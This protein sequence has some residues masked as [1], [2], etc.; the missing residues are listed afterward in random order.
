MH[1]IYFGPPDH[2]IIVVWAT[3]PTVLPQTPSRMVNGTLLPTFPA[4]DTFGVS[5]SAHTE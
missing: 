2:D 1:K 5:V 4:F 3:T